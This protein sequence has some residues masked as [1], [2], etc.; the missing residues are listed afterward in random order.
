MHRAR[1]SVEVVCN[2]G[3][4]PGVSCISD[5]RCRFI[6]SQLYSFAVVIV[7]NIHRKV[8]K[9]YDPS[10]FTWNTRRFNASYEE[11]HCMVRGVSCGMYRTSPL[12][13]GYTN[14]LSARAPSIAEGRKRSDMCL[15][16]YIL[17]I[18]VRCQMTI[19]LTSDGKATGERRIARRGNGISKQAL[20]ST[21]R[22]LAYRASSRVGALYSKM[23]VN[24]NLF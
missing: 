15:E 21:H 11:F 5:I 9:S 14:T 24:T 18:G 19:L 2:V 12:A 4:T 23:R 7:L 20:P 8:L 13:G 10:G 17:R 3:I 16:R 22:A 6:S 1:V